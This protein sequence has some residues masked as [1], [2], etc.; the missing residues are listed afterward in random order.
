MAS[1]MAS[2]A[3]VT[4]KEEKKEETPEKEAPDTPDTPPHCSTYPM[5][6]SRS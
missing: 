5:P 6:P 4:T 3:K 1:K 2:K